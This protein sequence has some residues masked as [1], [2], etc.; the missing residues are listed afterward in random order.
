MKVGRVMTAD[1]VSVRPEMPF[2]E[3]AER[4]LD[5]GVSGL[6]VIHDD[7]RLVGIVTEADLV[8]R[9]AYDGHWPRA[10]AVL[11]DVLS[12]REHHWVTKAAGW[13]AGDV[14][15]RRV[16]TCQ[17]DDDVRLVAR[18]M[19][20]RGVKRVPVVD[21]WDA[22]V[23]IVSRQDILRSLARPDE[24]IAAEVTR[25]LRTGSNRPDAHRV[26]SS[27][28]G[29]VESDPSHRSADAALLSEIL[30]LLAGASASLQREAA[31]LEELSEAE[32][33]VVR[34][35]PGNLR[36][37]EI[38]AELCVSPNTVRTHIRHV[39]AKLG[40]HSRKEAVDRAREVGVIG[41][42][43]AHQRGISAGARE[44]GRRSGGATPDHRPT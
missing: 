3:V 11:A 13:T 32:L 35:L 7:G 18:R 41:S 21:D 31:P 30:D 40:A 37:P 24:E 1:V 33:R 4:L 25:L 26:T 34:Y 16:T 19:L 2:K 38:A 14:M 15:T 20:E 28:T 29:L 12:A 27:D 6:P 8:A 42:S 10:L 22:L 44:P 39:Y 23:G 5:A 9:E 17:P 36:S 43:R